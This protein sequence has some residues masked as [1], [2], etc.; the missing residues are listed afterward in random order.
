MLQYRITAE[1]CVPFT[2]KKGTYAR[3]Q[4]ICVKVC[5]FYHKKCMYAT[6]QN[7]CGTVCP[8]FH[9]K[10]YVCY[11]IEYLEKSLSLLPSKS[12]H[13]LQYRISVEKFVPFTIKMCRYA[14]VQNICGKFVPFTIKSV[15]M[16][17]YRI[18]AEKFVPFTIKKY[19]CYSICLLYTSPSPRDQRGSRMPSSA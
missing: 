4:N 5:H 12:V 8:F 6:V 14:T 17:Q 13:M 7:I 1:K 2:I 19:V 11:S 9:K 10:V 18:S 15:C 3:V 16:L